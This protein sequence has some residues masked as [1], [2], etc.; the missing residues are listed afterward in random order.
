MPESFRTVQ[1]DIDQLQQ[2]VRVRLADSQMACLLQAEFFDTFFMVTCLPVACRV[3]QKMAKS[4]K[5]ARY[6]DSLSDGIP[7]IGN[8][9]KPRLTTYSIHDHTLE[10]TKSLTY[11]GINIQRNLFRNNHT[12]IIWKKANNT[13][14]FLQCIILH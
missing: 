8:K 10:V 12:N 14:A 4:C 1:T 11:L 3:H 7:H 13:V 2:E 6:S 9:W 5:P